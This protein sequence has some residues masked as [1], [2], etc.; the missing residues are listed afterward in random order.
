MVKRRVRKNAKNPFNNP[1]FVLSI[2]KNFIDTFIFYRI[3][4]DK[5]D[6]LMDYD[7]E[8]DRYIAYRVLIR[9]EK[10]L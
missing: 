9:K 2:L 5:G 7:V 1:N 3:E 8:N 10:K 6:I 4:S